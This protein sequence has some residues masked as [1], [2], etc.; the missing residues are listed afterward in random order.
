[1]ANTQTADLYID[2]ETIRL[3]MGRDPVYLKALFIEV[4]PF[5]IV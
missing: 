4:N 2:P 5:L 1:M 3:L